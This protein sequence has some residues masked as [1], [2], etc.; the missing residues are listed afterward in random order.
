MKEKTAADTFDIQ[1]KTLADFKGIC[2]QLSEEGHP[3][4]DQTVEIRTL[5][6]HTVNRMRILCDELEC[7]NEAHEDYFNIIQEQLNS[8]HRELDEA[9]EDINLLKGALEKRRM[10]D[11]T[12]LDGNN[13]NAEEA[14]LPDVESSSTISR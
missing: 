10:I 11:E 3:C 2:A 14:T 13:Q 5:M 6:K 7:E 8:R 1:D 9:Y 4:A 12:G